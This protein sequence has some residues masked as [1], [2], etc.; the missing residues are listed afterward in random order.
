MKNNKPQRLS[1][2][3]I[4][5]SRWVNLH[6][7]EVLFPDGNV[8]PQHHMLEFP[9]SSVAALVYNERQEVLLIQAYRYTTGTIE[10][11]VPAGWCE[12]EETIFAAIERE[13]LEE[14]GYKTKNH[15]IVYTFNPI[16]GISNAV[17]YIIHCSATDKITDFDR[18]EVKSIQWASKTEI[19]NMIEN[20]ILFEGKLLGLNDGQKMLLRLICD[21]Y[22]N[23]RTITHDDI[24][25]IYQQYVQRY[26]HSPVRTY[27]FGTQSWKY[28]EVPFS[29]WY[30]EELARSWLLRALGALIKKGYLT[31]IPRIDLSRKNNIEI[32]YEK[33]EAP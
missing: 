7:D 17:N 18:N 6:L 19:Q 14:T 5:E 9:R 25:N 29:D 32:K 23:G 27:D 22:K 24:L 13:V 33:Q 15:I 26:T 12:E 10:C 20:P 30:V 11:E 16:I 2:S 31:V 21:K 3:T 28:K 8:I 4:Y 1:R